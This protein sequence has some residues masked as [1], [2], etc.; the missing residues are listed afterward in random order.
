VIRRGAHENVKACVDPDEPFGWI[1]WAL[2]SRSIPKTILIMRKGFSREPTNN[3]ENRK[4]SFRK[5]RSYMLEMRMRRV[6]L[7][8]KVMR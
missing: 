4:A 3:N 8:I 6:E 7:K 5:Y 1:G 2:P